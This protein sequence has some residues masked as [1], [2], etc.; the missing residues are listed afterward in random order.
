MASSRSCL[1]LLRYPSNTKLGSPHI[2]SRSFEQEKDLLLQSGYQNDC[3]ISASRSFHTL[4][5]AM[6][7]SSRSRIS[8]LNERL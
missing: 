6:A 3:A 4:N 5:S 1:L 2:R 7:K 8:Y